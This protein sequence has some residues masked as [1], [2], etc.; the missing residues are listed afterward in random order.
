MYSR[1]SG[2][3]GLV[4]GDVSSHTDTSSHLEGGGINCETRGARGQRA[5]SGPRPREHP[6]P[7]RPAAHRAPGALSLRPV[8]CEV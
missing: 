5:L 6:G 4:C 8:Y 1:Y 3:F 7:R 2:L